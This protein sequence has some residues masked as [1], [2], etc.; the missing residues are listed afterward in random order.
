[1]KLK[2]NEKAMFV[3]M[4]KAEGWKTKKWKYVYTNFYPTRILC[5]RSFGSTDYFYYIKL[6]GLPQVTSY[7]SV[8]KCYRSY[9]RKEKIIYKTPAKL[10]LVKKRG[11]G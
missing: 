4:E 11:F 1:M 6:T 8:P 9:L 2:D 3:T 7:N 10:F 5:C